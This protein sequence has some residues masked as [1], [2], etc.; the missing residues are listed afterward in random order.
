MA[1]CRRNWTAP[2]SSLADRPAAVSST[3][4]PTPAP[5]DDFEPRP[6]IQLQ[7][8]QA[9]FEEPR[10]RGLAD[11]CGDSQE[12]GQQPRLLSQNGV[13]VAPSDTDASGILSAINKKLNIR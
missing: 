10:Y 12:S 8:E 9:D 11:C 13:R 6:F 4:Y 7:P 5:A 1:Q 3:R 2:A